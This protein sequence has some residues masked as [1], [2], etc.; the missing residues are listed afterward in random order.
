VR[1]HGRNIVHIERVGLRHAECMKCGNPADVCDEI[2]HEF[3][4]CEACWLAWDMDMS[5]LSRG[6][7]SRGVAKAQLRKWYSGPG[8]LVTEEKERA[9]RY[10]DQLARAL[11]DAGREAK[12]CCG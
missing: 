1:M 7:W 4:L 3:A 12:G 9:V 8:Y 2:D 5:G 11:I 10:L 6:L